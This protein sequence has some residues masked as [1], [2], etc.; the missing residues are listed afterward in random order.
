MLPYG[1][2]IQYQ[3]EV[4]VNEAYIEAL[5]NY[6][7]SKL[8]VPGKDDILFLAQVKLRKR[9]ALGNPI[10]KEH[11][12]PILYT[13]IHELGLPDRIVDKYSVKVIIENI[14]EQVDDQVWDNG[15]LEE[16]VAFR[17]DP[18][19]D[20]TTGDQGYK[21]A[22]RIQRPVITTKGWDVQVK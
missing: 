1:E 5:Y 17:C 9:D 22:N 18:D 19:V 12:N 2:D 6:I 10:R 3:K 8:V 14:I 13:R 11:S 4:E 21:N 7:G 16:I 15:I 20:I